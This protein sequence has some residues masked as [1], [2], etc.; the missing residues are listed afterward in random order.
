MSIA[1]LGSGWAENVIAQCD[2]MGFCGT[3]WPVHP[4]RDKIGGRTAYRSLADLPDAP[5]ATFIGV[6]RHATVEVV[7]ELAAMQAGGAICFASG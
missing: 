5:D 7:R 1:V 2:K 3:I 4:K 6:N